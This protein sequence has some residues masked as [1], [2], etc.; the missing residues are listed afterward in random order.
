MIKVFNSRTEIAKYLEVSTETIR[1]YA[2]SG[3]VLLSKYIITMKICGTR[4]Y[5]NYLKSY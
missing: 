2:L 4:L 5:A 3:K 1:R